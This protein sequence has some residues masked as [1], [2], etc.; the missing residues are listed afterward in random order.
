[1]TFSAAAGARVVTPCTGRVV[2][3]GPFRRFGQLVILECGPGLHLVLAG[4]EQLD[5]EAGTALLAGEAVGRL[6]A[7]ADGR[8]VLYLELRRDGQVVDPSPWLAGAE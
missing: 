7:G 2:F 5:T 1:V 6:A 4:F 8:G 3:A